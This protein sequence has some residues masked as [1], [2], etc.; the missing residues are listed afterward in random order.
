MPGD[1]WIQADP[2]RGNSPGLSVASLLPQ[3]HKILS[4]K[5]DE[6]PPA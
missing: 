3:V 2:G 1:L 4:V 5:V 6:R